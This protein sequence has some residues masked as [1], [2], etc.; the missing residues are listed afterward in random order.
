MRKPGVSETRKSILKF[1]RQ[2]IDERGYAPTVRDIVKGCELSSTAI[3][4]HH[5]NILEREG[6]IRRDPEVFRSIQLVEREIIEVPLLGIIAAGI[7]IPVPSSDSWVSTPEEVLKLTADV[8]GGKRNTYALRAKGT[9]MLDA[10]IGDGDI[11]IMEPEQTAEDGEMVAVWLKDE[12]ETTLKR[13]YRV[14]SRIR[15][16]PAN[17][18]MEPIYA[19][20]ENIEVQG[21]VVA[22]IR[23]P[24]P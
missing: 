19:H 5:L 10:L 18:Q 4:Q 6:H 1:I 23:R 20:P 9:S 24:N 7:P 12:Q 22:I 13:L 16:Q 8:I 3:V 21:K 17:E 15:L 2:F 14:P 11:V